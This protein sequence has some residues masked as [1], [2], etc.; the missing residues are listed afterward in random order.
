MARVSVIVPTFNRV[1]YLGETVAS[2]L[3]QDCRDFELVVADNASTDATSALLADVADPRLRHVR[4]PQNLGWRAN[5]NDALRDTESE[6]VALVAD[7]DRLLPGAL[8]RAVQCLDDAPSVGLVHTTFHVIDGAGAVLSTDG[9][10]TGARARDR[11]QRGSDF[12]AG[13]MRSGNPVC[14]SSVVMRTAALPAE[15]FDP[16]EEVAGDLVL[17]LR[18]ALDWDIAFLAT[19]GVELRVHD[20][21]LSNAFDE[22]DNFRALKE[23][24]LRFLD[25]N[26]TRLEHVP[27]LRR[28]ARGY[29]AA[30]MSLPVSIAARESRA[31]GY[32]ALRRAVRAR[33]QLVLE[34]RVWRAAAKIAAGPRALRSLRRLRPTREV[35]AP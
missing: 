11:T 3:D 9:N 8:A 23:C 30:A 33:P 27:A 26:S 12:I 5:F 25:A 1:D 29:T 21:Q 32:R 28:A 13:A 19:P 4:R 2:V 31:D 24:K 16:S 18:I 7:D 10:W 6:Y 35:P 34:P 14:L 22:A 17:F 20:G 15:A